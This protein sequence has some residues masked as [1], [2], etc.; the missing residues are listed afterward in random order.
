MSSVS[1]ADIAVSSNLQRIFKELEEEVEI[2]AGQKMGMSLVVYNSEPGSR[3]NYISNVDRPQVVQ[4]F[5]IL[6]DGWA[7]GMPDIPA[8]K[9]D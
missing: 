9:V 2:I 7:Q 1:K 6:L 4:V 3:L 5:R 8:H